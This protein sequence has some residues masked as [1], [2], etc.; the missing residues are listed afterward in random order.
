M[1]KAWKRT[2]AGSHSL[3]ERPA[4]QDVPATEKRL[5]MCE[6]APGRFEAVLGCVHFSQVGGDD[7]KA[8]ASLKGNI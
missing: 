5:F 7:P 2:L 8:G 1:L 6:I 3:P 4:I